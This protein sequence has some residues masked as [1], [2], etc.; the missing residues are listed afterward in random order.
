MRKL[1]IGRFHALL[2]VLL[3]LPAAASAD[4]K[5]W[6]MLQS[7][8]QVV[9]MRHGQTSPGTGDPPGMR[10]DDCATQRN[11]VDD[12]RR[13]AREVGEAFKSRR[14]PVQRLLSSPWCRCIQTAELAFGKPGVSQ[15]LGNLFGRPENQTEQVR[16]LRQLVDEH[17]GP[18]NLV[19]VSHGSTIAA[20]TGISPGMAELVVMTPQGDGRF[21]VAGLLVAHSR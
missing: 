14:V 4:E 3:A 9:L 11:L 17:R 16:A 8:G 2:L 21:S 18:G 19:L 10:L 12:G 7:G 1:A 5:L 13:Q 6:S 15:A 20:L